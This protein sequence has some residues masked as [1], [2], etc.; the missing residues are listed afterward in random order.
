MPSTRMTACCASG[1]VAVPAAAGTVP[2][3]RCFLFAWWA[4]ARSLASLLTFLLSEQPLAP[5]SRAREA[6]QAGAILMGA[7]RIS[8]SAGV[9]ADRVDRRVA[10]ARVRLGHDVGRGRRLCGGL[11]GRLHQLLH[12]EARGKAGGD[13]DARPHRHGEATQDGALLGDPLL[14]VGLRE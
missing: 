14:Q 12:E 10:G 7:P 6:R 11:L 3:A 4:F 13:R 5:V 1:S 8:A 9:A 2:A